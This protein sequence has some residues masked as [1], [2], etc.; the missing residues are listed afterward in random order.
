MPEAFKNKF[1]DQVIA[2]LADHLLRVLPEF[3]RTAFVVQACTGLQW[4]ELKARSAHICDALCR[5]LP[6]DFPKAALAITASLHPDEHAPLQALRMDGAGIRGW[7]VLPLAEY[8]ARQGLTHFDLAMHLLKELTKRFTAEFAVRTFILADPARAFVHL[9]S[10]AE[11]ANPHVRRLASE[12]ARPRLPWGQRLPSLIA[13][14]APLI[15]LLQRLRDDPSEYVRRS[16]ANNLNDISKDHPQLVVQ[17]LSEWTADAE[18]VRMRLAHHACRTLVKAGHRPALAMLGFRPARVEVKSFRLAAAELR[19]GEQLV[20]QLE[21]ASLSPVTQNLVID[22]VLSFRRA[23]GSYGNKVFKWKTLCL[24]A[25]GTVLLS[26]SHSIKPI[27]TRT[28]YSG[29]QA[30]AVQING[31]ECARLSFTLNA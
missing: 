13:D 17:L 3:D 28:Y 7:A 20:V 22:Y 30:V 5:H 31:L 6:S 23:N 24:A 4:L 2:E 19:L 8:V 14:P 26:K 27:T 12:G 10:W 16:V 15:P 1:N 29:A 9:H 11:D 18:P 25:A 21:I